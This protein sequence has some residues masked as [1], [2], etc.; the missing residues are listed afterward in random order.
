ME[1]LLASLLESMKTLFEVVM[2]VVMIVVIISIIT[3]III[4]VPYKIYR[5]VMVKTVDWIEHGIGYSPQEETVEII[6]DKILY[7]GIKTEEILE[8]KP[9]TGI[10]VSSSDVGVV[11][12][13]VIYLK[14]KDNVIGIT[15]N[16][17]LYFLVKNRKYMDIL[18]CKI[19]KVSTSSKKL[20]TSPKTISQSIE[21]I[22]GVK[23][24]RVDM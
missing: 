24:E 18:N 17:E 16:P 19:R 10:G 6:E 7:L 2:I 21:S 14:Y 20:Y 8:S 9:T 11:T 4:H 22:E 23:V 12:K 5:R 3:W 15:D 13:E 1:G